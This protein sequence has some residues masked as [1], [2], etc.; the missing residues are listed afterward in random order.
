MSRHTHTPT[1]RL[2]IKNTHPPKVQRKQKFQEREKTFLMHIGTK[3]ISVPGSLNGVGVKILG[4]EKVVK[5]THIADECFSV[6]CP[7]L[8]ADPWR[9]HCIGLSFLI[10]EKIMWPLRYLLA[11]III[12]HNGSYYLLRTY[13]IIWNNSLK[14]QWISWLAG[15][16]IV[17]QKC[18]VLIQILFNIQNILT[19]CK[20]LRE[21]QNN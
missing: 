5:H 17:A 7:E 11:F 2:C 12:T 20:K 14:Q 19:R 1:G 10:C 3:I 9:S 6:V 15:E 21:M 18:P 8:A 13:Y 4:Q 16:E